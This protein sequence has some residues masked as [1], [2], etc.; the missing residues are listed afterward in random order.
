MNMKFRI[1]IE[2]VEYYLLHWFLQQI[3]KNI[4]GETKSI[5][6]FKVRNYLNLNIRNIKY[7]YLKPS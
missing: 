4:F 2:A 1:N 6:T 7:Q 3:S 5:N